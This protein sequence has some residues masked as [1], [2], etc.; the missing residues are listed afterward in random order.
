M[1]TGQRAFDRG[2][3]DATLHAVVAQTVT[4]P[5]DIVPALP[6]DLE[7]LILKCLRKDPERRHQDMSDVKADLQVIKD[8]L[9]FAE[10]D[11]SARRPHGWWWLAA[12]LIVAAIAAVA[13]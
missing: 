6:A 5:S 12:G 1:V 13:V 3:R 2:T 9:E 7:T 8:E 10:T 11:D 4:L